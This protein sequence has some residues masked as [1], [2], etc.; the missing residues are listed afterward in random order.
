MILSGRSSLQPDLPRVSRFTTSKQ[1]AGLLN[2]P[3]HPGNREAMG[4]LFAGIMHSTAV[5]ARPD[6]FPWQVGSRQECSPAKC[7]WIS[8]AVREASGHRP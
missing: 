6:L 4:K 5:T 8:S 3:G 1:R 2:N 7:P